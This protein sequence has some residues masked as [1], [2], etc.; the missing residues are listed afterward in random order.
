ML[1][2]IVITSERGAVVK[3]AEKT[4]FPAKM[5]ILLFLM[6]GLDVYAHSNHAS[7]NRFLKSIGGPQS[8]DTNEGMV[9]TVSH[10][11]PC[12]HSP[13]NSDCNRCPSGNGCH[14]YIAIAPHGRNVEGPIQWGRTGPGNAAPPK[15]I[16]VEPALRPPIIES[17]ENFR[18][19]NN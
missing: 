1:S 4:W 11:P 2:L 9:E 6:M 17:R 8:A 15:A 14:L 18:T 5:L 16:S 19:K 13:E 12:Q 7:Q 10:V 3:R